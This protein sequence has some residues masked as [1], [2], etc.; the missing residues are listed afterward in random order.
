MTPEALG[1]QNLGSLLDL[2][3]YCDLSGIEK[4]PFDAAESDRIL[5]RFGHVY[6][7]DQESKKPPADFILL[8]EVTIQASSPLLDVLF[9]FK[10]KKGKQTFLIYRKVESLQV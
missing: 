10:K 6:W 5:K 2:L 8:K 7:V 1:R 9:K 4:R 3:C